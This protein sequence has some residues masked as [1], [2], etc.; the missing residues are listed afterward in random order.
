MH[1]DDRFHREL[2]GDHCAQTLS[3]LV[4]H[5]AIGADEPERAA[6]PQGFQRN[7][8]ESDVDVCGTAIVRQT[9]R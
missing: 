3:V 7:L 4:A 6:G 9:R 8:K 2:R 5:P 1:L